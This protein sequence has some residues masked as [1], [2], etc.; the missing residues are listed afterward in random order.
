MGLDNI[1]H[2]Y[3]CITAKTAVMTHVPREDGS[4]VERIDCDATVAAGGC[5][6]MN[7]N[8]P[9]EGR[10]MGMLGTHCWY[11]GK[12]G[13]FLVNALNS[14]VGCDIDAVT[15][16]VW[17]TN[18][19]DSFYGTNEEGTYRPPDACRELADQME[20]AL[21]ER[22]GQLVFGDDDRTGDVEYALWYLRWVAEHC[23]GMVAWY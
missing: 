5:P 2:E 12:Y 8:P 15:S 9:K 20:A 6:Y 3:P 23:D 13:N 10:V 19:D 18:G 7:A 11:R 21:D 16:Y 22:G 4:T 14:P 17:D 1:P